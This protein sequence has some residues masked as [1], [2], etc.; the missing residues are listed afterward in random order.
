MSKLDEVK[1]TL[2]TLRTILG[3]LSAFLIAIGGALGSLF[4]AGEIDVLFWLC[5]FFMVIFIF[6]GFIVI[7]KIKQ[8]TKEIGGL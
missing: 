2:N 5:T 3:L 6:V 4:R 8:K 1:E 7:R